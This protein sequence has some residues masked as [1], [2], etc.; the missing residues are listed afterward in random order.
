[1]GVGGLW[2]S[3]IAGQKRARIAWR[4][5]EMDPELSRKNM[6]LGLLLLAIALVLLAGSVAIAVIY[7]A[8]G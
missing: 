7:D 5:T 1:M 4:G 8:L 3:V 6:R 2:R